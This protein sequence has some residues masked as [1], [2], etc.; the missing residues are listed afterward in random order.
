[1]PPDHAI[2]RAISLCRSQSE[3]A[4]RISA[5][6]QRKVAAQ[7]IQYWLQSVHGVGA[8]SVLAVA[9]AVE[10]QVTPHELRP[11]L[12]PHPDDGLPAERRST[13]AAA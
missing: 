11:D 7:N 10:F 6:A 2:Y 8:E 4:R 13:R 12:Y 5:V 3:L 9:A 1:M